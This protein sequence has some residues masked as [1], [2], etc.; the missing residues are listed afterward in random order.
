VV[1]A[2][3]GEVELAAG[4]D[5]RFDDALARVRKELTQLD[6]L[7]YRA[8]RIVESLAKL[9]QG[10][11]LLRYGPPAVAHAF[12]ASRLDGDAGLAFG[13]L[14]TGVDTSEILARV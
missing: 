7:E 1:E 12:C 14:P 4:A 3:F 10:S 13:T 6:D 2:F 8:R 5:T 9:L 11:L